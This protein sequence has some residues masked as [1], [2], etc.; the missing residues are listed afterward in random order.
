LGAGAA[1]AQGNHT[2]VRAPAL[3]LSLKLNTAFKSLVFTPWFSP[4]H[5]W[6]LESFEVKTRGLVPSLSA[7]WVTQVSPVLPDYHRLLSFGFVAN[8]RRDALGL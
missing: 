7:P 6:P 1:S 8:W 5:S 2:A 4:S 3:A